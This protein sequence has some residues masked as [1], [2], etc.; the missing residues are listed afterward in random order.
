M[1]TTETK[2][3]K[4]LVHIFCEISKHEYCDKGDQ[5]QCKCP[6]HYDTEVLYGK[7]IAEF[8]YS[9]YQLSRSLRGVGLSE[10]S[11]QSHYLKLIQAA[12]GTVDL[13]ERTPEDVLAALQPTLSR[14]YWSRGETMAD[15]GLK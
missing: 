9:L 15:L 14:D 12:D 3:P 7:H 5:D 6:C 2:R 11:R 13:G 8:G 10:E 1:D 4:R